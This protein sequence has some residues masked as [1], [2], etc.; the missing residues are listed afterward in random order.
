MIERTDEENWQPISSSQYKYEF[1]FTNTDH[2]AY[3]DYYSSPFDSSPSKY[4]CFLST[5]THKQSTA[6]ILAMQS[7]NPI[8][9][10]FDFLLQISYFTF[11]GS[12]IKNSRVS[13]RLSTKVDER[14]SFTHFCICTSRSFIADAFKCDPRICIFFAGNFTAFSSFE[15][16]PSI[17]L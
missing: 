3:H 14:H 4:Y 17:F 1:D 12:K 5:N 6:S 15:S 8:A 10:P 2:L 13:G 11:T 16:F 7:S 9:E